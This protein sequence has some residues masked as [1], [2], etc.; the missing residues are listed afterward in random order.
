[1]LFLT[2]PSSLPQNMDSNELKFKTRKE[3]ALELGLSVSSFY[4]KLK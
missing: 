4:R 3:F 2:P 1:M